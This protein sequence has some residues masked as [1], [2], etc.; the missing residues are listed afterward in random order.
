MIREQIKCSINFLL[1]EE[2]AKGFYF[3]KSLRSRLKFPRQTYFT[4]KKI[5]QNID[6]NS[7]LTFVTQMFSSLTTV[8]W[9]S[10]W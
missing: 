1:W 8:G 6:D 3:V 4:G 2:L 10:F 5:T 7:V 9:G